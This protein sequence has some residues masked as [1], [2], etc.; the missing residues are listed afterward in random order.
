MVK[1]DSTKMSR[2]V[3]DYQKCLADPKRVF[4]T[5]ERV[6][7]ET[8]LHSWAKLEILRRWELDARELA[9]AEDEAMDGG[10]PNML[11]RVLA[12]KAFMTSGEK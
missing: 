4:G 12:A 8:R 3:L 9:T 5:P 10:E 2:A 7:E 11:D 6:L 1:P